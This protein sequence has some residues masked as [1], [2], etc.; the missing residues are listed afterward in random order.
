VDSKT[1]FKISASIVEEI[2]GCKFKP[3]W[4]RRG[5]YSSVEDATADVISQLEANCVVTSAT[6]TA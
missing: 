1:A 3:A 6:A 2:L 5:G 4:I